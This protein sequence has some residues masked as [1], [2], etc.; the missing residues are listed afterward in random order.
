V[1]LRV[2]RRLPRRKAPV[3]DPEQA[4]RVAALLRGR[5]VAPASSQPERRR[6]ASRARAGR[7]RLAL[8]CSFEPL[9]PSREE[10][11]PENLKGLQGAQRLHAG[12]AKVLVHAPAAENLKGFELRRVL[13]NRLQHLHGCI[14]SVRKQLH[15]R[16]WVGD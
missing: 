6:V 13:G 15:Q 4:A 3:A 9:A 16:V 2:P 11:A 12:V 1:P 10:V 5:L 7:Q 14:G 8:G